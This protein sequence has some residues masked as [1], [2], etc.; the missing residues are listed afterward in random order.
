M[1]T[2]FVWCGKCC[3]P[4]NHTRKEEKINNKVIVYYICTVCGRKRE[5]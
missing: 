1:E 5:I 2:K 3:Q 4:V